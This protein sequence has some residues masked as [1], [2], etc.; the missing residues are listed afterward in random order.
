MK[1]PLS[2]RR[3][4]LRPLGRVLCLLL[5]LQLSASAFS[6]HR[7]K[8]NLGEVMLS[9]G[10]Q[11]MLYANARSQSAPRQILVNGLSLHLSTGTSADPPRRVL[12]AFAAM[13]KQR[14][15]HL[16]RRL[17]ARDLVRR[18]LDSELGLLDGVLRVGDD[19]RGALACF[20]VGT[21]ELSLEELVERAERVAETGDFSAL[22]ALRY[23]SVEGTPEGSFFV[24]SWSEGSLRLSQAFP[25]QGDAPGRDPDGVPR[26]PRARR[27]LSA[28]E[29]GRSEHV[30]VYVSQARSD[31]L[32]RFYRTELAARGFALLEAKG[33]RTTRHDFMADR[34]G[35]TFAFSF[36]KTP[37]GAGVVTISSL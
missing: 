18:G 36:S 19:R 32:A 31:E 2:C 6:L 28:S 22:G 29:R 25:A 35:R 5:F 4:A 21:P 3:F 15:G 17:A 24:A 11:L 16:L 33:Q 10:A 14:A 13:C 9:L 1:A 30:G 23:V 8:A 37:A 20:D 27:I 7:A 12:D 26:P 34:A